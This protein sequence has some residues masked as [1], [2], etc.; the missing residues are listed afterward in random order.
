MV[1]CDPIINESKGLG[2]RLDRVDD[3]LQQRKGHKLC[4]E[5]THLYQSDK[6]Y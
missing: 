4:G 6:S 5:T 1:P 2:V 3:P